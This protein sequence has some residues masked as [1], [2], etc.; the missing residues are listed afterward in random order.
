M[1]QNNW[2]SAMSNGVKHATKRR[3]VSQSVID[4]SGH[5]VVRY[6]AE[7]RKGLS[8]VVVQVFEAQLCDGL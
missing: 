5:G 6:A 1:Q 2:V 4:Y 8:R 3:S 7:R